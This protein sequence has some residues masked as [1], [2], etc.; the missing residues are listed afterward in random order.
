MTLSNSSFN[1]YPNEYVSYTKFILENAP[2]H[3]CHLLIL[4]PQL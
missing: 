3:F 1:M 4:T 2:R